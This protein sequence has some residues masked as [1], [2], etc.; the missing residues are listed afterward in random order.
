MLLHH[1]KHNKVLHEQVVLL[2]IKTERRA[3]GARRG[4]RQV[5]QLGTGSS[6]DRRATASWRR[7]TCRRCS[8]RARDAGLRRQAARDELLPRPRAAH[9]DGAH[10][11]MA[12]WRKK[13]FAFMSRNARPATDVL[14]D[15][16]EPRRR[17][18]SP[19]RVLSGEVLN[20]VSSFP[21]V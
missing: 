3:R 20:A 10:R 8:R 13:L 11:E 5:E 6:G 17:A 14:P 12:R 1:L 16:A 15:P 18:G 21:S 19:D 2:S 4:A 7:R 9:S